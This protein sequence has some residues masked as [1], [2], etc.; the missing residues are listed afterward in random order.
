MGT[1]VFAQPKMKPVLDK[2]YYELIESWMVRTPYGDFTV[3]AGFMYDGASIPRFFWRVTGG[4][5]QSPRCIAA[6]AHDYLY[7]THKVDRATAD[8][9]YRDM[10]FALGIA[11]YKARIEYRALRLFGWIAWKNRGTMNHLAALVLLA[12]ISLLLD[13]CSSAPKAKAADVKGMYANAATETV[14]IGAARIT[15]LPEAIESF[16]ARYR[17][18]TAWLS[19]ATKTHELEIFMTGTNST[20]NAAAVVKE[21]CNAFVVVAPGADAPA[22]T[23]EEKH[24]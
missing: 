1:Y 5:F 13:G 11:K 17:E 20:Q 21:I 3:P 22:P 23:E 8:I 24:D 10:Q 12:A 4:P 16:V 19:P 18:D 7:A 9:I 14:A 15:I 6:L 2:N